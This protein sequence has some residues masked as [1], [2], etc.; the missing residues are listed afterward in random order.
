MTGGLIRRGE[1]GQRQAQREDDVRRHGGD[2][3]PQVKERV[4]EGIVLSQPSGW[5][6]GAGL[7]TSPSDF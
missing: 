7:P 1:L 5:G 4:L 2:D 6:W 3:H